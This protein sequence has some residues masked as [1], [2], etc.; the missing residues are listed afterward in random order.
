M[1]DNPKMPRVVYCTPVYLEK[2]V[3]GRFDRDQMYPQSVAYTLKSQADALAEALNEI[4][5]MDG[6]INMGNYT[7]DDVRKLNNAFIDCYKIA[8]AALAAYEGRKI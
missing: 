2:P 8:R 5:F 4:M 1:T 7:D 3:T 6:E